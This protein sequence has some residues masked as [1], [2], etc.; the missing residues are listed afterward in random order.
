MPGFRSVAPSPRRSDRQAISASLAASARVASPSSPPR[1]QR[2][3]APRAD[4]ASRALVDVAMRDSDV[5]PVPVAVAIGEVLGDRYRAVAATSAADR[6]D[7]MRLALG[8]VLRQQ[9]VEQ[10][11]QA[12]VEVVEPAVA[13]DVL[14][15]RLLGPGQ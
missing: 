12:H 2:I 9:E 15:D 5:E 3:Q 14:D 8:D 1:M 7:E 4:L 10:R 11:V 6:D 13:S